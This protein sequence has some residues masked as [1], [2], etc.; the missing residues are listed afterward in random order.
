MAEK[1]KEINK[2]DKAG[3]PDGGDWEALEAGLSGEADD[4]LYELEVDDEEEAA[5]SE[6]RESNL[7]GPEKPKKKRNVK[8]IVW[9]AIGI[10]LAAVIL[11]N[12]VSGLLRGPD[13]VYMVMQEVARGNVNQAL[14]T[15]GIL[16]TGERV[17]I[18]CPV[19]APIS[20]MN[21]ELGRAV[22]KDQQLFWFDTTM[23]ERNLRTATANRNLSYSQTQQAKKTSDES[24]QSANEYQESINHTIVQRDNAASYAASLQARY[25]QV[26]AELAALTEQLA[27]NPGDPALTQA[28]AEK[29]I[30]LY[31][32]E[33]ALQAANADLAAQNQ[34][35]KTLEGYRD[36]EEMK[37]LSQEQQNQL[38]YQQVPSQVSYETAK[39][40]LEA[41]QAG[42]MAPISGVV[43]A[44]S[45]DVGL[46]VA[47]YTPMCT[48]ESLDK[49][50]VIVALSRYDLER[51]REGQSA[52]VTTAGK[53]YSATV[54]KIDGM[55][56]QTGTS[57]FVNCT[58]SILNPDSDI[59]LGL[60]ANVEIST[61]L[62]SGVIAVPVM[63]VNS[64]VS[65]TYCYVV[66]D[67]VAHRVDVELGL[68]SENLVEITAGLTEGQQVVVGAWDI[69]EGTLV[70]TDP[71]YQ[72]SG[73]LIQVAMGGS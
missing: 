53:E 44:L 26:Q 42:V 7:P 73:G 19:G 71:S 39:E 30:E 43:S 45:A 70:T 51:V 18:Y 48:I 47:Q 37:V 50:N 23:L 21:V 24:Q 61:G 17:T 16:T 55:A 57:S 60:E 58:V 34:L 27:A 68:S 35:I 49:V 54:S 59:R 11:V 2:E 41:G 32:L 4:E 14:A 25:N 66:E 8:K 33:Q 1:D 22:T 13:P 64:D 29:G 15:S 20:E 36:A 72:P 56:T 40:S 3:Q 12:I 10:V 5:L 31:E 62:A 38:Y 28:I 63:A 65:G 67:G 52:V 9:A 6:M 69:T 46:M